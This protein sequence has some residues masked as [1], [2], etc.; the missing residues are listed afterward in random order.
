MISLGLL[1]DLYLAASVSFVG[2]TLADLGG[3]N[4]L[5]PVWA[6]SPVLFGPSIAN[7]KEAAAYIETHHY[8]AMVKDSDELL[9]VLKKVRAGD[10]LFA[11]KQT[12][13]PDNSATAAVGEYILSRLS[14]A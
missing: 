4:L 10:I 6:G 11:T 1:N 9:S 3:H 13:S 12:N 14:H 7:V 8:G 5:E 2:G